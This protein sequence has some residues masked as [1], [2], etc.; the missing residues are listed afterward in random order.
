MSIL[1][2]TGVPGSGKSLHAAGDARYALHRRYPRPV[3]ANFELGDDAPLN[4]FERLFYHYVP[5]EDMTSARIIGICDEFWRNS[6]RRFREDYI[7]LILDECQMIF[8]SR[9]W[10][11]KSRMSYLEFLSQSRKYGVRVILIAQSVK[12]IDTQFRE[13]VEVEHNHRRIQSFGL[14]GALFAALFLNRVFLDVR[15]L[16]QARERLGMGL[17][18]PRPADMRMYDSYARISTAYGG[19][20]SRD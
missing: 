13:L 4:D 1:A 10:A 7:T 14:F 8:N 5:N 2:Y 9:R 17:V 6:G 15:Y 3:I 20:E 19:G 12:M 16:Y 18:L 11:D